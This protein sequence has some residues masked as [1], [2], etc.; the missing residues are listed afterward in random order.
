MN[1]HQQIQ[2]DDLTTIWVVNAAD[3]GFEKL[4]SETRQEFESRVIQFI[5]SETIG[6][7]VLEH[8]EN[9]APFLPNRPELNVSISHSDKWFALCVSKLYAVGIDIEAH[10]TILQKVENYFLS[11]AELARFEPTELDLCVLWGAK[12]SVFKSLRGELTNLKQDIEIVSMD[13]HHVVAAC[14]DQS[15]AL[16]HE[17]NDFYTL[18]YLHEAGT[19]AP[20]RSAAAPDI[21]TMSSI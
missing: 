3:N 8:S 14:M 1:I 7:S 4:A 18:V 17:R 15:F 13:E 11:N 19:F 5:L 21:Q 6:D 20:G 2:H 12:E 16:K 9:G 10:G